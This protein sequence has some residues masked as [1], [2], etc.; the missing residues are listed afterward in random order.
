M[1]GHVGQGSP[2]PPGSI[3]TSFHTGPTRGSKG[4]DFVKPW[5]LELVCNRSS[6]IL[7]NTVLSSKI[8]CSVCTYLS[9]MGWE[10]TDLIK[11]H[12]GLF[13][14]SLP[15]KAVFTLFKRVYLKRKKEEE[16]EEEG[17]D[18]DKEDKEE[19]GGKRRHNVT[20]ITCGVKTKN[21]S[22]LVFYRKSLPTSAVEYWQSQI[23][24]KNLSVPGLSIDIHRYPCP[25]ISTDH[26]YPCRECGLSFQHPGIQTVQGFLQRQAQHGSHGRAGGCPDT[27]LRLMST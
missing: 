16:E 11:S 18:V 21:I 1:E 26:R 13:S 3:P 10:T 8:I 5:D 27:A 9:R 12:H 4:P 14:C 15:S 24:C 7:G 2:L 22:H 23:L 17:E 6:S 19:D 25:S 20:A